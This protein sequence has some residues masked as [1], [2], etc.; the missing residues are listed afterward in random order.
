[1][2]EGNQDVDNERNILFAELLLARYFTEISPAGAASVKDILRWMKQTAKG[3][4][5]RKS[6]MKEARKRLG[7]RSWPEEGGYK[8]AW[9]NDEDPGRVWRE[10]SKAVMEA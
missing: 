6:E 5:I 3:L 1:M 10:K 4:G 9:E 8:W 2:G 7:I